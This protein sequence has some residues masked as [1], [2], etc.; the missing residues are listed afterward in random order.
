MTFNLL[1]NQIVN[2]DGQN[3]DCNFWTSV[4]SF[5]PI[6][7]FDKNTLI[8]VLQFSYDM[9]F[10]DVGIHRDH[11][12]GGTHRRKNGELFINTFQGKLAEFGLYL[13]LKNNGLNTQEPDLSKWGKGKWDTIDLI[14]N[15]KK[16][17]VKSTKSK[18]NLLLLETKDWNDNGRYIPNI[19]V[20]G[21]EYDYF[22]LTRIDPDGE[23]IIKYNRLYYSNT[24]DGGIDTLMKYLLNKKWEFDIVGYVTTDD[25]IKVINENIIIKQG[26]YLNRYTKMDAENYYIQS[27]DMRNTVEL[28]TLLK[29]S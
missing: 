26:S 1:R 29:N 16:L 14:V 13:Y 18:G 11:R 7:N 4:K 22:I 27:G 20:D 21:G 23:S 25:L 15:G 2:V 17:N 19:S 8:K 5:N 28:G 10:G 12:S 6:L 9:T 24:V 3:R